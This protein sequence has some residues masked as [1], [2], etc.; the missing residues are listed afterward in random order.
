MGHPAQRP[1]RRREGAIA[2]VPPLL[3]RNVARALADTLS[4]ENRLAFVRILTFS[5][6]TAY[7]ASLPPAQRLFPSADDLR[8]VTVRSEVKSVAM[9]LGAGLSVVPLDG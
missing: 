1:T 6:A 2:A 3:D 8:L 9:Q 4:G 5:A 7:A